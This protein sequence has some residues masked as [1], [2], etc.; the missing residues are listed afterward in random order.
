MLATTTDS[1]CLGVGVGK[2]KFVIHPILV[3]DWTP[4][5]NTFRSHF[6]AA[7]MA[8]A[9]TASGA[10]SAA[11]VLSTNFDGRTVS[12]A[13]AN[14][15]TWMTNG[16]ASPGSLTAV[17]GSPVIGTPPAMALFTTSAATDRFAVDRN[18]QTESPWYVDI[19]L[20]VLAGNAI[21]LGTITLD[22]FIF[23]NGGALQTVSRDLDLSL[24]LLGSAL[25]LIDSEAID[26]I[27]PVTGALSPAQP[28]ALSFDLSGNTLAAGGSYFLR[29]TA[30]SNDTLGN[31][32]GIDNFVV[33]GE[34]TRVIPEPGTLALLGLA[35]AGLGLARS[36]R[37]R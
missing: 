15:L 29:L 3:N 30:S 18:I 11:L 27:Y 17:A 13:T 35:L 9:L 7:M 32:A 33:N 22:A 8:L 14:N 20:S 12:G 28:R 19:P 23:N 24:A 25:N 36:R 1:P 4:M 26:N 10:A 34:L 37:A 31:N 6:A 21:Q 5:K 16:V 2:F